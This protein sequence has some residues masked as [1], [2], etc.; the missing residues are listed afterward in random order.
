MTAFIKQLSTKYALLAAAFF[1]LLL[2]VIMVT[3]GYQVFTRTDTLRHQL[4]QTF[5]AVHTSH[6]HQSLIESG[7]YISNQMFN[8]LYNSDMTRLN[9][10][11]DKIKTWLRPESLI[12]TDTKGKIIT[13]GTLMNVRFG[14]IIQIPDNALTHSPVI[15]P[16]AN[17]EMLYFAIGYNGH[18]LGVAR[19][20]IS[21]M[22][23]RALVKLLNH[24]LKSH[25]QGFK[26]VFLYVAVI[27]LSIVLVVSI[28]LGWYLSISLSKPLKDMSHAANE[29]ARGNLDF[30]LPDRHSGDEIDQLIRSLQSMAHDLKASKSL[31]NRSEEI[32]GY[33]S[34]EQCHNDPH[35]NLSHGIYC[36]LDVNQESFFPTIENFIHLVVKKDKA[37]VRS[38]LQGHFNSTV[39]IEFDIILHN[40]ETRTLLL[41]GEELKQEDE[42]ICALGT[43]QDITQNKLQRETILHQAHYDS[44]TGL[45]NRFL[46]LDRLAQ[47][48]SDAK[49]H[50]H[51]VAV[52]FLDLDD[53]KKINDTLG[54]ES[55][56]ELLK[57]VAARFSQTIRLE[58]T[59]GRLGGDEFI[60]LLGDIKHMADARMVAENLL[61]IFDRTFSIND[62]ELVLSVSIGIAFFPSDGKD[63]S[64]V[65]RNADSAMYNAKKLGRNTYSYFTEEMNRQVSRQL[66]LEE[67]LHGALARNE[68]AVV[69]QPKIILSTGEIVGAEALLRWHNPTLGFVSPDEFIPIAERN[70]MIISIGH[71]VL[72]RALAF[73]RELDQ[74]KSNDFKIA[75]NFSP[76]QFRDARLIDNIKDSI[77]LNELTFNRLELEITEGVL[78][79]ANGHIKNAL[80]KLTECGISIALDDFGTGYSSLS[81]LR[82]YPF[83]TLKIDRSF[84]NDITE[85]SDDLELVNA[86]ISM[87]H[88]LN[89][90]VVAEGIETAEQLALIKASGCELGQ[91]YYFSKPLS[92][93]EFKPF[94]FKTDV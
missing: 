31:L 79:G 89:L 90:T 18:A 80:D 30:Y 12:I 85:D 61:G 76:R 55:G 7:T 50:H 71:Y 49:R 75:V 45:P 22:E 70:G 39:E 15:E 40:Q 29:F 58:D 63:V 1:S 14:E 56:D 9:Q 34:W 83:N 32:G 41:K 82:Q 93:E 24:E 20:E 88:A 17:G 43:M 13:D 44:L 48:I 37:P 68:F 66:A 26:N 27:S 86:A 46:S 65:V 33:G 87:A 47:M 74:Y 81:Y 51:Y 60:V 53:F 77:T 94:Y 84:I 38:I 3:A 4:T 42:K 28:A 92:A 64:E 19:I 2:M 10:E 52:L 25:W 21:N 54:H 73:T 72:S 35:L 23:D 69:Y 16:L 91:G 62:R 36:I 5:S 78:I 59:V 6:T 57:Q 67:Q 11:I 8:P